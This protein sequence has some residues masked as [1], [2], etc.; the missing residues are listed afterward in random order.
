MLTKIWK[1]VV[2]FMANKPV[3][4]A[5]DQ[6]AAQQSSSTEMIVNEDALFEDTLSKEYE[7]SPEEAKI[8]I[9]RHIAKDAGIKL[10][11]VPDF[12]SRTYREHVLAHLKP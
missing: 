10:E 1:R 12:I 4:E 6:S 9:H 5:P 8:E 7:L 11:E 2:D 3:P